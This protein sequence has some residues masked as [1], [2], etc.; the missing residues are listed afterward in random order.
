ME[1]AIMGGAMISVYGLFMLLYINHQEKKDKE[2][3]SRKTNLTFL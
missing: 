2:K 3:S 1:V